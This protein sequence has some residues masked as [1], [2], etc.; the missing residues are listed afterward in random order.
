MQGFYKNKKTLLEEPPRLW[1]QD[2]SVL[3]DGDNHPVRPFSGI[4][5]CFSSKLEGGRMQVLKRIEQSLSRF[6]G[7]A[8]AVEGEAGGFGVYG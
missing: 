8:T 4:P 1:F 5:R 2:G 6:G 7:M 3:I